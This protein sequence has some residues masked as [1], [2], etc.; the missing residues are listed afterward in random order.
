M[1]QE[2]DMICGSLMRKD[3]TPRSHAEIKHVLLNPNKCIGVYQE[4]GYRRGG[5]QVI[6]SCNCWQIVEDKVL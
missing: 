1:L 4:D 2:V 5:N 6:V 3:L